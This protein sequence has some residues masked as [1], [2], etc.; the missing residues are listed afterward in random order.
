MRIRIE[1]YHRDRIAHGDG[2]S[3]AGNKKGNPISEISF[4]DSGL[5]ARTHK[6]EFVVQGNSPRIFFVIYAFSIS[7][8]CIFSME[9]YVLLEGY[10]SESIPVG[11]VI[12]SFVSADNVG[13][14]TSQTAEV[15]FFVNIVVSYCEIPGANFLPVSFAI[16]E[17]CVPSGVVVFSSGVLQYSPNTLNF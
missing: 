6:L 1:C 10:V 11:Q 4:F 15:H 12:S 17:A 5:F 7:S 14:Q 16:G 8:E 3:E 13:L 2:W 9:L